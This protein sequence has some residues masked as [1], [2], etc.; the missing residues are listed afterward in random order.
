VVEERMYI[1]GLNNSK[2]VLVLHHTVTDREGAM[3]YYSDLRDQ[4]SSLNSLEEFC[5]IFPSKSERWSVGR[6]I[7][8]IGQTTLEDLAMLTE[9]GLIE[10]KTTIT[11]VLALVLD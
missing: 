7:L 8:N 10:F 3:R 5:N 9:Q 1:S 11:S 2:D 4:F 6:G